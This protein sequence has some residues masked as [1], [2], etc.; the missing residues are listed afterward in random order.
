MGGSLESIPK[1]GPLITV[2]N[3]PYCILDGLM[4]SQ[5]RDGEFKVLAHRAFRNAPD[6]EK[7]ILPISFD[8][9]KEAAKHNLATR[10]E[11]LNYLKGG[12]AI[13]VFP[14][15]MVSTS[16]EA[17]SKPLD[18]AW[19]NFTGKIVARSDATVV[20]VFFD[21][22]NSRLFQIDSHLHYTLR[23]GLMVQEFKA[24]INSLVRVV[25]GEPIPAEDL[26]NAKGDPTQ[27]MD[28]LRKATYVFSPRPIDVNECGHDF[29]AK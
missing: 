19:R 26:A 29:E 10:S 14:G 12:G 20:P 5:R 22:S 2:A 4:L 1:D 16:A 24:R 18:L 9:T 8:E 27:C 25:I 6:L 3:H 11:A 13:G 28:F 21:G 7:V 23:M 15:G 17:F